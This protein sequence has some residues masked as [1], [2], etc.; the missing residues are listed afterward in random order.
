M[1]L[2]FE[3]VDETLL[4]TAAA[5][6]EWT[7]GAL[8]VG[9]EWKDGTSLTAAAIEWTDG[10]VLLAGIEWKDGTLSSTSLAL[11]AS[12]MWEYEFAIALT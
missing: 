12:Q 7:D 5:A 2:V 3:A 11:P 9:I 8:L 6:V 4:A 10:V 1:L